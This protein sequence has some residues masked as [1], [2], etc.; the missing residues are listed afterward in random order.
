MLQRATKLK[1]WPRKIMQIQCDPMD[2]DIQPLACKSAKRTTHH[3]NQRNG[4]S[5]VY[6]N[7]HSSTRAQKQ[8]SHR[9]F[10]GET[11]DAIWD[12]QGWSALSYGDVPWQ[13]AVYNDQI[14]WSIFFLKKN[15]VVSDTSL[16]TMDMGKS[17]CNWLLCGIQIKYLTLDA[18][19]ETHFWAITER[20]EDEKPWSVAAVFKSALWSENTMK[21]CSEWTWYHTQIVNSGWHYKLE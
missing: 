9:E 7:G 19:P 13:S 8:H 5:T 6:R 3:H 2:G 15:G 12:R 4:G 20:Y 10:E 18:V 14:F 17:E 16:W 1:Q 21:I 11:G